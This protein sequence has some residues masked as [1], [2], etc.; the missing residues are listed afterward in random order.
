MV[1]TVLGGVVI[2]LVSGIVGKLLGERSKVTTVTC[3]EHQR[4]CQQLILERLTNL[5]RQIT[6]LTKIVND[7][8]LG[9]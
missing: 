3:T 4:A 6:A 5:E 1:E 8:V 9:L 7:K 2:A